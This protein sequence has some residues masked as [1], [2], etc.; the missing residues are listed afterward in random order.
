MGASSIFLNENIDSG[1][2][3]IKKKF[4]SPKNKNNIDYVYDNWARSKVLI[5]TL[6]NINAFDKSPLKDSHGKGETYYIIHPVLKH[7]AILS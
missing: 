2:L 7:I 5:E 1:P 4:P 3:L 6:K